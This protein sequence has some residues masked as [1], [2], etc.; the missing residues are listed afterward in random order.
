M[1]SEKNKDLN[2]LKIITYFLFMFVNT[3]ALIL[4]AYISLKSSVAD[5]HHL[6]EDLA[7][8]APAHPLLYSGP[9]FILKQTKVNIGGLV[10]GPF[11][12]LVFMTDMIINGNGKN[13]KLLQFVTCLI[14]HLFLTSSLEPESS[15]SEP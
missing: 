5:P 8:L 11:F 1:E 2:V 6:Y 3:R 7:A 14:I 10:I 15:Q 4:L 12:Y 9:T 13:K